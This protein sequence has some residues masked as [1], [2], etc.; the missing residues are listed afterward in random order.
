MAYDNMTESLG[1]VLQTSTNTIN[2]SDVIDQQ[3]K[4]AKMRLQEL[5]ELRELLDRNPDFER[6]L[7]LMGIGG[8]RPY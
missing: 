3:L 5:A 4:D 6:M 8:M 2:M 1:K 7:T